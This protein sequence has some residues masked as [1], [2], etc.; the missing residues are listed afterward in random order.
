M[1]CHAG[2]LRNCHNAIEPEFRLIQLDWCIGWFVGQRLGL[3]GCDVGQ[4]PATTVP[5]AKDP[6]TITGPLVACTR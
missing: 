3:A 2:L 6:V 5:G 4:D 1:V